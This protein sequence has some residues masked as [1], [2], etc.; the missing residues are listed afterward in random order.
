[1]TYRK[2]SHTYLQHLTIQAKRM[3]RWANVG[4]IRKREPVAIIRHVGSQY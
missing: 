3:K 2:K 4:F 1:M